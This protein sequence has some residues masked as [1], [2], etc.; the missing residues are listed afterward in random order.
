MKIDKLIKLLERVRD[1]K[2]NINVVGSSFCGTNDAHIIFD[3]KDNSKCSVNDLITGY[4]DLSLSMNVS[5]HS[6]QR[7]KE[8]VKD[9]ETH[10]YT[11]YRSQ[12]VEINQLPE[13]G[14][15]PCEWHG[16]W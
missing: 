11:Y 12:Y 7:I 8:G 9:M 4:G 15:S 13:P 10:G 1:E 6:K 2:G 14:L 3:I 16:L 5:E